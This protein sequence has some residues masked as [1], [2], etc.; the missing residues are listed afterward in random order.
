MPVRNIYVTATQANDSY[1]TWTLD[2]VQKMVHEA[3][4][5]D[6]AVLQRMGI[7]DTS[8]AN[9]KGDD[10]EFTIETGPYAGGAGHPFG[11]AT[12]STPSDT[13][14]IEAKVRAVRYE[15]PIEFD[16]AMADLS[17]VG[18]AT[19]DGRSALQKSVEDGMNARKR[20]MLEGIYSDGTGVLA[21]VSSASSSSSDI[22]LTLESTAT[23]TW[24]S[25]SRNT[26]KP[27]RAFKPRMFISIWDNGTATTINAT[28]WRV[29]S[30]DS[31][32]QIT[33]E[34]VSSTTNTSTAAALAAG[35]A[36][37]RA[38]ACNSTD[39]SKTQCNF[40][41]FRGIISDADPVTTRN[42]SSLAYGGLARATYPTMKAVKV[43]DSSRS[44][45]SREK[46]RDALCQTQ[47]NG[48]NVSALFWSREV[49]AEWN[50][51]YAKMVRFNIS[52]TSQGGAR[53][54]P[55]GIYTVRPASFEGFDFDIVV[56]PDVPAYC[57]YGLT[58]SEWSYRMT[59]SGWHFGNQVDGNAGRL[60][61]L[62]TTGGGGTDAYAIVLKGYPQ[63]VCTLPGANF[64]YR[65]IDYTVK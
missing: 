18:E 1:E 39:G 6:F 65:N 12:F 42:T 57:A 11:D 17:R 7:I 44:E 4:Y 15:I 9:M 27:S 24:L 59:P 21:T 63:M 40:W 60:Q 55:G 13:A 26:P 22:I 35:D 47:D 49:D 23:G 34:Y 48:G 20:L 64:W 62:Y 50:E 10:F 31:D 16:G 14:R 52:N 32:T 2:E 3:S 33:V 58:E 61:Y 45:I 37:C 5:T 38:G 54:I 8:G 53:R 25:D 46:L 56:D 29:K 51:L 19:K 43:G 28:A 36:I 41:G 30:I